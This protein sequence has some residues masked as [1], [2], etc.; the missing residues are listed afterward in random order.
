VVEVADPGALQ[1]AAAQVTARLVEQIARRWLALV[2]DPLMPDKRAAG[3]PTRFSIYQAEFSDNVIFRQTQV[4]NRVYEQLLRDHLHLG[5]ADMVKVIFG[6]QI[7]KKYAIGVRDA[8]LAP[9]RGELPQDL[10]QEERAQAVQ[11]GGPR[12]THRGLHQ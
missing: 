10:L 2:P 4:L 9:R 3:Y 6:R 11:Q 12:A 7:R 8:D 1:R 5:R